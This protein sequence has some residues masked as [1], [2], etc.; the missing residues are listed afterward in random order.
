MPE[1]AATRAASALVPFC[2]SSKKKKTEQCCIGKQ[3]SERYLKPCIRSILHISQLLKKKLTGFVKR[4]AGQPGYQRLFLAFDE[5]L[6]RPHADT[7]WLDRNRNRA[8]NT[9][10]T[11]SRR[12]VGGP[13]RKSKRQ[14]PII[15]SCKRRLRLPWS[16][17]H[18]IFDSTVNTIF[19]Q[20]IN[21]SLQTY[22][23]SLRSWRFL[24]CLFLLWFAK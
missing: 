13:T 5:E 15:G 8:W 23:S 10:V 7:S 24:W 22:S 1:P 4:I 3:D 14:E 19:I 12:R 9:S 18:Q 6:R 20:W 16:Y 17:L 11:Q 2:K 21:C